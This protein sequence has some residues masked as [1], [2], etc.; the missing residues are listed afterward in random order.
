[1]E[2]RGLVGG[3]ENNTDSDKN[4]TDTIHGYS[5]H[6]PKASSVLY[7]AL[8]YLLLTLSNTLEDATCNYVI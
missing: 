2:N 8:C 5:C 4:N 3:G 6:G 1:M 7:R